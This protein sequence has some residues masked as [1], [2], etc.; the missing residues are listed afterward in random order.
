MYVPAH[1]AEKDLAALDRLAARDSFGTLVS[2]VEGAPFAT[3]LPV[4]YRRDGDQV[5][6]TGHWARPNL[7]WREIESQRVLFMFHGPH[8]YISPRWYTDPS[9]QVP[10]WN[11]MTAHVYGRVQLIEDPAGL[12]QIVSA[13]ADVYESGAAAP[14][15]FEPTESAARLRGIVGFELTADHI[16]IK[17]KLSQNQT[18]ANAEGAIAGIKA[19]SGE[20][21]AEV[22]SAMQ[23]AL[24]RKRRSPAAP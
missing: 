20:R 21:G 19:E 15:R 5:R 4:L 13:L 10:T 22:A 12:T 6:L 24:D 14:W 1:F 23:D 16:E 7:Q 2:M 3:H 9:R 17:H 11:Y 18:A 8:T